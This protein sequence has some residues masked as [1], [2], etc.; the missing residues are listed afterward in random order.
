MATLLVLIEGGKADYEL[1][2]GQT[3]IGRHPD[4]TITISHPTASG[5][6]AAIHASSGEFF[7]EDV[8]S[9][10]GTF[11]NRQQISARV[12]LNHDDEIQFGD[13]KARFQDP[14][15]APAP[16]PAAEAPFAQPAP[17][18]EPDQV[19]IGESENATITGQVTVAGRF[20]VLDVNP[21]AKLKA[22]LEISNG[23]AGTVDL[24]ALLPKILDTL[25]DIFKYADRGC[26]SPISKSGR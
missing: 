17:A 8:G 14:D 2:E 26:R 13:A 22:V 12:K 3:L 21:E 20:G 25:F 1:K 10:N 5:R 6:H 19:S 23:L 11:V 15:A 18:L 24:T 4:C 9:S 16:A 7:L